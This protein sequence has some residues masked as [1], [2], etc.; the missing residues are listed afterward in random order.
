MRENAALIASPAELRCHSS[1][2]P[3]KE[4]VADMHPLHSV[5]HYLERASLFRFDKY[6]PGGTPKAQARKDKPPIDL[7]PLSFDARSGN[8]LRPM[9]FDQ[10]V[11]QERLRALFTRIVANLKVTGRPLEHA[12]FSGPSGQGKTTFAQCLAHELGRRVFQ[13]QPPITLDVLKAMATTCRDGDICI[14]DEVHLI[15]TPDRRGITQACSPEDLYHCLEDRRLPTETGMIPFPAVTFIGC[16]T[17]AGLLPSAFLG[18]F[19]LQ[20]SLDPYSDAEMAQL[21]T[22]NVH[23]LAMTITPDAAM[24][25]GRAARQNPRVLND[26]VKNARSLSPGVIDRALAH[27]VV[28]SLTGNT[29]DGLTTDMAGMLRFLLTSRRESRDGH[30]VYQGSINTVATALGKSRDTKIVA[31]AIE[32]WLIRC[33]YV[34]VC[35]GGRQLSEKGIK[36]ARELSL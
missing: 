24:L 14:L 26:Y 1:V 21:A 16:T 7:Q 35:H 22:A 32:P 23:A 13:V 9:S 15:V 27:E 10:M 8:E 5:E 12:L 36:R 31:L 18:R 11:G 30:V 4:T 20:P 34:Q 6:P 17:D 3:S 28:V 2:R 33:G 29:L 25:F 19:P